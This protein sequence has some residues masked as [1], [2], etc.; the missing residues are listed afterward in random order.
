MGDARVF[1]CGH[2]FVE[3]VANQAFQLTGI[4]DHF[5]VD[6]LTDGFENFR[7]GADADVGGDEGVLQLIEDIS[8]DFLL[9]LNNIVELFF[10]AG[11]SFFNA[12]FETV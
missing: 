3:M 10:E 9:A 4:A 8:V 12:L 7:C 2:H 11:T 5:T 1:Q 6:P